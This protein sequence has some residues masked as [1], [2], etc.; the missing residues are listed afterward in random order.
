L[1]HP[2]CNAHYDDEK[3]TFFRHV[4]LGVAID[5]PR[6]LMVPTLFLAD[7]LPLAQI[8]RS[9]KELAAAGHVCAVFGHQWRSGRPGET[10]GVVFA[11]Y[12]PTTN[13]RTCGICGRCETQTLEWK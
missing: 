10:D 2:A 7:T 12:H 8:S 13:Y 4:N 11:D 9:V 6:G 3:T 1:R 5:T